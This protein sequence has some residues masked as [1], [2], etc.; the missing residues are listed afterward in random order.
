MT[1]IDIIP[2]L[3]PNEGFRVWRRSTRRKYDS[4]PRRLPEWNVLICVKGRARYFVN[5]TIVQFRPRA[6][7]VLPPGDS[8]F[9]ISETSEADFVVALF[10]PQILKQ[11]PVHPD[12]SSMPI[13]G[14]RQLKL[15]EESAYREV[16]EMAQTLI[17]EEHP[18]ALRVGIDWWLHRVWRHYLTAGQT[19]RQDGLH[20]SVAQALTLLKDDPTRSVASIANSVPLSG[21]HLSVL[22][23]RQIGT[24]LSGY[25]TALRIEMVEDM[26]LGEPSIRLEEA[27]A[28]VGFAD[29]SSFYRAYRKLR[30]QAPRNLRSQSDG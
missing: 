20:P 24:T 15:L 14:H 6:V 5:G 22:F 8:H 11:T 10:V 7:L 26:V 29:Y 28:K 19:I 25:R 16:V 3:T 23:R 17:N 9:L 4:A 21:D 13:G 12:V 27:A 2:A 1:A 30:G 18:S